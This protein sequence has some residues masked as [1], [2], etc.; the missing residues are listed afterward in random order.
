MTRD[1]IISMARELDMIDFRD[2]DSDPHV[3][4]FIDFLVAMDARSAAAE[5]EECAKV[6]EEHSWPADIDWWIEATK[7]DVSVKSALECASA[8]RARGEKG[9]S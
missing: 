9:Q 2:N 1:E 6:C 5:R 3:A 7:K 4:Q 8:I